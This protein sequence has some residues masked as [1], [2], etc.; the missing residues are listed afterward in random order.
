MR[1]FIN[2]IGGACWHCRTIKLICVCV[3]ET[4]PFQDD[5]LVVAPLHKQDNLPAGVTVD[6]I[7]L[8]ETKQ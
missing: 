8:K 1:Q 5:F 4:N 6:R 7:H 2:A 3:C